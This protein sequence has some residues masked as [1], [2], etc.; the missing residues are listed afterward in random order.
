MYA[1]I[2]FPDKIVD[3]LKE[4][5]KNDDPKSF[6]KDQN[7]IIPDDIKE[8]LK[9]FE[10]AVN[11]DV[12]VLESQNYKTTQLISRDNKGHGNDRKL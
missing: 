12:S 1:P 2:D 11:N 4:H 6:S 8:K 9:A 7:P 3:L 5:S 10:V